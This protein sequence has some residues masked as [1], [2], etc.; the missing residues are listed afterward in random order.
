MSPELPSALYPQSRDWPPA[1][2]DVLEAPSDSDSVRLTSGAKNFAHLAKLPK[3]RRLW[4]FTVNQAKL[5]RIADLEGLEELHVDGLRAGGF[6]GLAK[7]RRLK[8]LHLE[9]NGQ[10]TSLDWVE[11]LPPLRA[12][13]IFG[14]IGVQDLSPLRAQPGLEALAV[15]GSMWT[16][17][18]VHTL[19][20]LASLGSL[21][22][23]DLTNLKVRDESLEPLAGLTRLET[24]QIANFYT[25][26]A[27]ARLARSL[28]KTECPW[29]R[30]VQPL[31]GVACRRCGGPVVVLAGRGAA[32]KCTACDAARIA[33]HVAE[34]DAPSTR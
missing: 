11:R 12:L 19:A 7:L 28:P 27:F 25:P 32:T 17:M 16:R 22:H 1:V 33:R 9:R 2:A 5:D 21:R 14:F 31:E 10:A 3:L 4:A 8:I 30:P 23:L 20:P 26:A 18:N 29:F 34:F 6:G 15:A 24:L 13:G